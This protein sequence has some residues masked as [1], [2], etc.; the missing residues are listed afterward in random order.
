[1]TN[2]RKILELHS[3]GYSQ[4]SIESS[5]RSS[6]QTVRAVLDR[7]AE[8]N[9][10]WP[11]DDDVTNEM[12]DEL[13]CGKRNSSPAPYA[14]I[15]FDYI[16][17]ELSKKGVTLT[18]LWQEYCERAYINGEMPYMSTQFGD[19]YRRWARITKATMR[20]THKPGDTMQV[21][22]A[23]GTIPYF[24][25]IGK[26]TEMMMDTVVHEM[27]EGFDCLELFDEIMAD[28]A[29]SLSDLY[30][31]LLP[32]PHQMKAESHAEL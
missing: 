9:I 20:V 29:S 28:K 19:K 14:V 5:V 23:G 25:S 32:H 13:F 4:R 12:L 18:L 6:H 17:K 31:T 10:T 7:A 27:S 30:R 1:M 3:Q 15:D 21:D 8:L 24:D 11:L 16:H 2:Y 22:W 26:P